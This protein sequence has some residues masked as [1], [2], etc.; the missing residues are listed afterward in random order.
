VARR[1]T[2]ETETL[3]P[4]SGALI[5]EP[6]IRRTMREDTTDVRAVSDSDPTIFEE[7]EAVATG[8]GERVVYQVDRIQSTSSSRLQARAT[9]LANEIAD[10]P[11]Y[12]EVETALDPAAMTSTPAVGDRYAL[13]LPAFGI[14]SEV[15]IIEADRVIDE[16]GEVIYAWVRDGE[17]PDFEVLV[18]A[19][20][21]PLREDSVALCS[22]IRTISIGHRITDNLGQIPQERL[23]EV[24][25]ALEYSLG[26]TGP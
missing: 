26:L 17:N 8:S 19:G 16:G 15:R 3:S 7:A 13:S 6:R 22:Q 9:R 11:E 5:G 2:D 24:D 12:L 1:G 20:V 25:H 10:A 21:S 18:E 14:S 23:D 4:A